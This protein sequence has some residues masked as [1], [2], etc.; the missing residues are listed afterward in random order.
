MTFGS[1][2]HGS[3]ST[4]VF[5]EWSSSTKMISLIRIDD[6]LIH[7]QV[8]IG[9]GN[10]I[11]PDRIVVSDDNVAGNEWERNLYLTAAPPEI[12]VSILSIEETMARLKGG[13]FDR[14]RIIILVAHPQSV[15]ELVERGLEIE[16][17]NVGGLHYAEGKEKVLDHVFLDA[18]E[19]AA[20]RELVKRG[21][22]LDA[23]AL[24][25]SDSI[26]LNSRVV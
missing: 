4:D 21:I 2:I 3:R 15:V 1:A 26:I 20:L 8:V 7:A 22:T 18:G 19:K 5:I 13:V 10:S 24:P 14:E 12:K 6:R 11:N 16:T 9:W 17:V 23:R 25:D